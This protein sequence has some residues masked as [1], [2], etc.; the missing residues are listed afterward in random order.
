MLQPT[1]RRISL[2]LFYLVNIA[3]R[4]MAAHM[5][6]CLYHSGD[7]VISILHAA[8]RFTDRYRA[9]SDCA[10]LCSPY[11]HKKQVVAFPEQRGLSRARGSGR[12]RHN[13]SVMD[14]IERYVG[15]ECFLCKCLPKSLGI[16]DNF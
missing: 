6:G 5:L 8:L 11:L 2:H 7:W 9:R 14:P 16:R 13:G 4:H 10:Y 12:G 1:Q 3:S 15:F